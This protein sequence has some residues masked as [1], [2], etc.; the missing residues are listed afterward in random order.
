MFRNK[1]LEV[2]MVRDDH[3]DHEGPR[4]SP[5]TVQE[6]AEAVVTAYILM[7]GFSTLCS[8]AEH[9]VVTKVK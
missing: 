1:K 3:L 9:F 7:K 6:I 5:P 8:A 2:K 4:E